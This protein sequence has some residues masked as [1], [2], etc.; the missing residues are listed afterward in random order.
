MYLC[1][2]CTTR[3]DHSTAVVFRM[4]LLF[5]NHNVAI[6][7]VVNGRGEDMATELWLPVHL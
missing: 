5:T 7:M 2:I 6:M 4:T 1:F 3:C